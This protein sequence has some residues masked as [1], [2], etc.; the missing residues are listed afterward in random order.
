MQDDLLKH[1]KAV[2]F[3]TN[4]QIDG[5]QLRDESVVIP[6]LLKL[7]LFLGEIL[8]GEKQFN[9]PGAF[10]YAHWLS[11]IIYCIKT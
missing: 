5:K 10:H 9:T 3:V 1:L 7:T 4:L 2:V 8:P 6:W 11:K